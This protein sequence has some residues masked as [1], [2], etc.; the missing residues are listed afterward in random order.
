[1]EHQQ[2]E[3]SVQAEPVPSTAVRVKSGFAKALPLFFD[4]KQGSPSTSSG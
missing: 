4:E 3:N 1:M 2:D